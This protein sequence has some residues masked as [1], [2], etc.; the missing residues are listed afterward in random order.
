MRHSTI[1]S[2]IGVLATTAAPFSVLANDN[3]AVV[4]DARHGVLHDSMFGTCVRTKWDTG[5]D[6]CAPKVV[7][8]PLPRREIAE[9]DRTVYFDF[10]SARLMDSERRKLDSLT[11][12][13]RSD[14][15]IRDVR[16]AGFADRMGSTT[17]NR[18]LS[19][20]RAK[21]VEQYLHDHEY[22]NTQLAKTRWFGKE[23]P[24]ANCPA[25]LKRQALI[26][27]LQRDRRV[28]IEIDY[29]VEQ[30]TPPAPVQ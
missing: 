10:N 16:I 18:K 3:R 5:Q 29:I 21:A 27:C 7:V 1:C 11:N 9:E 28:V 22:L 6:E 25:K 12:I 8:A 23:Y 19:E 14:T 2:I 24:T 4:H 13:L 17:Y 26:R 20:K 15:T 30:N